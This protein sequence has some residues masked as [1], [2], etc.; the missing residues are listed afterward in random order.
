MGMFPFKIVYGREPLPLIPFICGETR[1]LDFEYLL[2][3]RDEMI[4]IVKQDLLKAQQM[5]PN[6]EKFILM[7]LNWY[8][9]GCSLI[10]N[11]F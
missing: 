3:A 7:L 10:T 2:L 11:S 5:I 6:G 1:F 8:L 4:S 9:F